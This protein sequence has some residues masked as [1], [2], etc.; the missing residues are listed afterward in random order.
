[1]AARDALIERVFGARRANE[2]HRVRL[3]VEVGR[4][5]KVLH[6]VARIE[7]KGPG[8]S[9]L[10]KGAGAVCV[11]LPPSD[12]EASALF[13]LLAGGEAWA[14]SGLAKAVGK[15]QRA[16]Q[17]AL[18]ELESAGKVRGLGR[19]RSRRWIAK[20]TLGIATTLLLVAPGSLG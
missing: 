18:A 7:A 4:L 9:L 11:L 12:G 17:R 5:R 1:V 2:S 20:P 6:G 16:V 8:F 10:P 19:G 13:S 14:T 15:S 3:R